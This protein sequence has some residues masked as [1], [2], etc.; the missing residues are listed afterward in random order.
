MAD[1][2]EF[3]NDDIV[4]SL[5]NLNKQYSA[6]QYDLKNNQTRESLLKEINT[7]FSQKQQKSE[8]D[9]YS[10][11][12]DGPRNFYRDAR[13]IDIDNSIS[14]W[15]SHQ[16]ADSDLRL[17]NR[18]SSTKGNVTNNHIRNDMLKHNQISLHRS[19][20][21][22]ADSFN[23]QIETETKNQH[24]E[25]VNNFTAIGGYAF[26]NTVEE[27]LMNSV[28]K[29]ENAWVQ[30][31]HNQD[32]GEYEKNELT[33]DTDDQNYNNS[34]ARTK[35]SAVKSIS[36]EQKKS[37]DN[38]LK[39]YVQYK[40]DK[41]YESFR[42]ECAQLYIP[43]TTIE[44]NPKI[45]KEW[46]KMNDARE[47]YNGLK[48][49]EEKYK[50]QHQNKEISLEEVKSGIKAVKQQLPEADFNNKASRMK[51]LDYVSDIQ[52]HKQSG[53]NQKRT[54]TENEFVKSMAG[55]G[56]HSSRGYELRSIWGEK[57]EAKNN[58]A[59]ISKNYNEEL[60]KY[61]E[62]VKNGSL[63]ETKEQRNRQRE[64]FNKWRDDIMDAR[65]TLVSVNNTFKERVA[66]F[67]KE[68][69][70]YNKVIHQQFVKEQEKEF[71][72]YNKRAETQKDNLRI[73]P[74]QKAMVAQTEP[75][76]KTKEETLEA[77]K[78]VKQSAS[79]SDDDRRGRGASSATIEPK[80]TDQKI[81]DTVVAVENAK[82]QETQQPKQKENNPSVE[83]AVPLSE[84]S[85]NQFDAFKK[86][87]PNQEI[88]Y[89]SAYKQSLIDAKEKDEQLKLQEEKIKMLEEQ[90]KKMQE[91]FED[92]K[93]QFL[94]SK[95][96]GNFQEDLA[97]AKSNTKDNDIFK[98]TSTINNQ[99][100]D[101][102]ITD[103]NEFKNTTQPRVGAL[104]NETQ[105][106]TTD[107]LK[108][109]PKLDTSKPLDISNTANLNKTATVN[110]VNDLLKKMRGE[111]TLKQ[112]PETD[113]IEIKQVKK[114]GGGLTLKQKM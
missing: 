47:N 20:I 105:R 38:L 78:S 37:E 89:K 67:K 52:T 110:N 25:E 42:Q 104:P 82:L 59:E 13:S 16:M 8:N 94:N 33:Q 34:T 70:D 64:R 35:Q 11:W 62:A 85:N 93:K 6:E 106:A 112:K 10:S 23:A 88:D 51:F 3:S 101:V 46:E 81:K 39:S 83:K 41:K 113:V 31:N 103:S 57:Q 87:Q 17:Q 77:I 48:N 76:I 90:T 4:D 95:R 55:V 73:E 97:Q 27:Q 40:K 53:V 96:S 72:A 9:K 60:N 109:N 21:Y 2:F 66:E 75:K 45:Y 18:S 54:D 71:A 79:G 50:E 68:T 44:K 84:K 32:M 5:Y 30:Y 61:K 58:F 1:E 49:S 86:L 19:N 36:D 107:A 111:D 43:A 28:H 63:I 56:I 98:V 24:K 80:S 29:F 15:L 102:K 14:D 100:V 114:Q 69:P 74:E 26:D 91:D 7:M 22:G 65:E 108:D 92:L 12:R 99:V